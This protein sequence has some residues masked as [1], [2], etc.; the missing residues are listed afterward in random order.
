VCY[1]YIVRIEIPLCEDVVLETTREQ[2]H[3]A[4]SVA[5]LKAVRD[6]SEM[7]WVGLQSEATARAAALV[8]LEADLSRLALNTARLRLAA[9]QEHT[10][11]VRVAELSG[12]PPPDP[13]PPIQPDPQIVAAAARVEA[14]RRQLTAA[15]TALAE[16]K[17]G[18]GNGNHS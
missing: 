7:R 10:F 14:V 2:A 15:E 16:H 13:L 5:W 9:E 6:A 18:V 8:Q 1:T 17:E 12:Q 3:A 4:F 11:S